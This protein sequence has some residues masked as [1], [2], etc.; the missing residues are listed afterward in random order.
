MLFLKVYRVFGDEEPDGDGARA[1]RKSTRKKS[2]RSAKGQRV[3]R[4][5]DAVDGCPTDSHTGILDLLQPIA[6]VKALGQNS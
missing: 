5:K 3:E 2:R 4:P 6:G 1:P